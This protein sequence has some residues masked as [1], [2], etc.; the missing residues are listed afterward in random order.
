MKKPLLIFALKCSVILYF[1]ACTGISDLTNA[2]AATPH[3][4]RGAW[5]INLFTDA[6]INET[7]GLAGYVLTF[8]ASG[9]ITASKNNGAPITG[10]WSEDE[11]Q[12]RIT[13]DLNTNDP[14][15][16]RLND[17][18]NVM[19][20]TKTGISFKNAEN[21]SGSRLQITSL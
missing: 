12:K 19:S 8:D 16:K 18:W 17:Y 5:K 15:L 3:V 1:A 6:N 9:K 11:I 21:P 14:V 10:N 2:V 4:T 13:I 7:P 20:V